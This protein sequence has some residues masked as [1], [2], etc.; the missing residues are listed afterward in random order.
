MA[1]KTE[2]ESQQASLDKLQKGRAKMAQYIETIYISAKDAANIKHYL[3]REPATEKDC[4]GEDDVYSVTAAFSNGYSTDIQ[5]CG[6]QYN[7]QESN[8]SWTQAILYDHNNHEVYC[9]EAENEFF[10]K[11]VL[12]YSNNEYIIR[13]VK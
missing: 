10:G 12:P 6:V 7:P 9:T 8:L 1:I 11:W 2:D 5:M 3:T 13:I 4:F